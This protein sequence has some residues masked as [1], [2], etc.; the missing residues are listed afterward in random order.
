MTKQE[1]IELDNDFED[2]IDDIA[3]ETTLKEQDIINWCANQ[4]YRDWC[5]YGEVD[6]L[7]DCEFSEYKKGD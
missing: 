4:F 6:D 7:I 2:L 1:I 3:K 5:G